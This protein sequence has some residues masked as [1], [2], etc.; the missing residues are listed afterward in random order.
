MWPAQRGVVLLLG[1]AV[2]GEGADEQEIHPHGEFSFGPGL[3]YP[4]G[5]G[6]LLSLPAPFFSTSEAQ[7]AAD[8]ACWCRVVGDKYK[9]NK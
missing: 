9:P 1:R 2:A 8:A 6:L 4:H 3:A 5:H 7:P